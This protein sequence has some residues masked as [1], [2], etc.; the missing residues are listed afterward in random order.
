MQNNKKIIV[1][2]DNYDIAKG[3]ISILNELK[4]NINLFKF[5]CS[6][7]SFSINNNNFE[8]LRLK[9]NIKKITSEFKLL[10]SLHC[11]QIIPPQIIKSIKCINLHP[12]YNP[13]NRGWF[14]HVFSILNGLPAGAS[15]H[16]MDEKIDHGPLIAQKQVPVL[17]YDTSA[18]LYEKI[19]K[20]ELELLKENLINILNNK[21]TT[22]K[23]DDGNINT[24]LDYE[25]LCHIKTD[26]I[27]TFGKAIDRLR[28]LSHNNY[29]NAWFIDKTTGKKIFIKIELYPE[30]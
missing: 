10:I 3:F 6:Y 19:Q 5:Y 16:E 2:S 14:P 25:K 30:N 9:D 26:E 22:I 7:N 20:A 29:K 12:G 18:S 21:Y 28:A 4:I 17:S 1:I 23:L 13:Y 8:P 11:L 24:K 15:L 27:T